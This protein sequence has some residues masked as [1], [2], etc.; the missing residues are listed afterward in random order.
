M[1]LTEALH[2]FFFYLGTNDGT[3]L[4]RSIEVLFFWLITYMIVSEFLRTKEEELQYLALAFGIFSIEKT[5]LT[6]TTWILIFSD[7]SLQA[8]PAFLPL[9]QFGLEML[10]IM[11]MANAFGFPLF[12]RVEKKFLGSI[13]IQTAILVALVTVIEFFWLRSSELEKGLS[14]TAFW[15]ST[16][17]TSVGLFYLLVAMLFTLKG[18]TNDRY[19]AN[20]FLAF[21]AYFV[22]L[23]FRLSNFWLFKGAYGRLY[24][25]E[26]PLPLLSALLFLRFVY[27]KLV[28]KATLQEKLRHSESQLEAEK[29]IGRMKDEFVST[30]SHELRTPLTSIKLFVSLLLQGKLGSLQP[31]QEKALKTVKEEGDRLANLIDDLLDLSRLEAGKVKLKLASFSPHDFLHDNMHYELAKEKGIKVGLKISG[32]FKVKAD[33]AKFKQIFINLLSNAVKFT[34][35]GGTITIE[36]EPDGDRWIF[37]ISDTGKGIEQDKLPRLFEK[38]F[39]ANDY[40]TRTQKGTGLG[41]AIVKRSVELHKGTISAHSEAGKGSTF[42]VSLPIEP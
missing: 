8:M 28:D 21:L 35:S 31:K 11:M 26:Q 19:R 41:L 32:N 36:A 27:L 29:K 24:V 14:F 3:L 30:V 9:A 13:Y 22:A 39:Q 20:L 42:I 33:V 34:D 16:V 5:I 17:F 18:G 4:V 40:M 12:R 2:R 7:I 25:A 37:K 23:A 1:S 10:A 6:F 38:F 15:G